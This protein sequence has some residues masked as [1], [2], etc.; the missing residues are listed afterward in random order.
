MGKSQCKIGDPRRIF[1]YLLETVWGRGGGGGGG[2][3]GMLQTYVLK[4]AILWKKDETSFV[5]VFEVPF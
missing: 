3:P 5:Q 4:V 1:T 2:A